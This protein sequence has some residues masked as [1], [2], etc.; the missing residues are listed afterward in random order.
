MTAQ[1][2]F[3]VHWDYARTDLAGMSNGFAGLDGIGGSRFGAGN[4]TDVGPELVRRDCRVLVGDDRARS[5]IAVYLYGARSGNCLILCWKYRPVWHWEAM[6]FVAL[7]ARRQKFIE[8]AC[9]VATVTVPARKV[10]PATCSVHRGT[11]LQRIPDQSTRSSHPARAASQL[12]DH[13]RNQGNVLP[14]RNRP[15]KH[16]VPHPLC[17]RTSFLSLSAMRAGLRTQRKRWTAWTCS[18][19]S[20]RMRWRGPA[21]LSASM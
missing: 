14:P 8:V 18:R 3:F 19:N 17:W 20:Q 15:G 6:V 7:F 21:S 2:F 16:P 5:R 12:K 1:G 9:R 11:A 4:G 13:R 10:H